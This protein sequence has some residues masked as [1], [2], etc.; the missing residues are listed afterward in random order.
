MIIIFN[1]ADKGEISVIAIQQTRKN[2]YRKDATQKYKKI[3][4]EGIDNTK[5]LFSIKRTYFLK[6]MNLQNY[7][8]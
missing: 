7:V 2:I 5:A 6:L 1:R 3:V 8:H 4:Q